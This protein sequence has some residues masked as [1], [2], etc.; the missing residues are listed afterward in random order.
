MYPSRQRELDAIDFLQ[1]T[2]NFLEHYLTDRAATIT[3]KEREISL[4]KARCRA[5][6]LR[7]EKTQK[8]SAQ[9]FENREKVSSLAMQALDHAISLGDE[10]VAELALAILDDEYAKD[11]FGMMNKIGGI[12]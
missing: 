6:V 9:F 7:L 11:F 2:K 4:L 3:A 5:G 8:F 10:N 1:R 12:L